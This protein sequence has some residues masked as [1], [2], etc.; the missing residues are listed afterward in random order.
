M[1]TWT[2]MTITFPCAQVTVTID[3]A[4]DPPATHLAI[5]TDDGRPAHLTD[6]QLA[7]LAAVLRDVACDLQGAR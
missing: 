5:R 6:S 4:F 1:S 2:P 3:R 7:H